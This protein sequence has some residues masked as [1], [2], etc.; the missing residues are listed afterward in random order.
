MAGERATSALHVD[1]SG[2]N[3]NKKGCKAGIN[4]NKWFGV[5][6]FSTFTIVILMSNHFS[7]LRE[8]KLH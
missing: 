8:K 5:F 1:L 4:L 3:V 7:D 2:Q 6:L